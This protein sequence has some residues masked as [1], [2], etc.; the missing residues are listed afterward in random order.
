MNFV[1][2]EWAADK[3]LPGSGLKYRV[4]LEDYVLTGADG[5]AEA[6]MFG[7]SYIVDGGET[8][9]PVAFAYNG[10]PG[11]ASGWVHMGLLGPEVIKF[12]GYPDIEA[13]ARWALEP[14][15]ASLLDLCD[16]VVIDAVGTGWARLLKEEAEGEYYS[17]GGDARAFARFIR[18]WLTEHGRSGAPVY[19][20]G[21]SYGTIRN[22]ALAD[23]LD[24]DID[25]RGI[26]HI[27]TSLNVGAKGAVYVEPNVRRLGA[28]AAACWFHHHRDEC[29]REEFVRRAMDFAWSDYARALLLGNRL[30]ADE[31]ETV[32]EKLSYYSG[33]DRE[34]LREK[35][36]RFEELDFLL[37]LKHG[38]VLSVYDS[39]L[40]YRLASGEGYAANEMESADIMEPDEN[41]DAF[42][43]LIG[44]AFD[45]AL[46][47]YIASELRA[48][49]G[50]EYARDM[51]EISRRWDYRGYSKDTLSLPEELMRRRPQLRMLFVNGCYDLSSTFDFVDWYLSRY[52]LPAERTDRLVL[53]AG[54]ASYVGEG[55]AEALSAKIRDF[56]SQRS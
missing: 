14:N 51:L 55:M 37:R 35:R 52:D 42:S 47:S 16:I 1:P 9:R 8:E 34:F 19:L 2:F 11:A 33:I 5:S 45:E 4:E 10:G 56:I 28:N 26:V 12:P 43:S 30:P 39:R 36:L 48:P 25:L 31:R 13:P 6:S 3:V 21:E 41:K 15:R 40:T 22:V 18:V 24:E 32:L 53:P 7:F 46:E 38:E 49:E 44:S 50:R 23:V 54:H 29:S 27:G 17:T 20:I